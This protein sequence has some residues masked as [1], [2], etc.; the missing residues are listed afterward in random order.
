MNDDLISRNALLEELSSFSMKITG[1]ANAM[2]F[3]IVEE[4]KKSITKIIDEQPIVYD[5]DKVIERLEERKK[6]LLKD[7][8]LVRIR[9]KKLRKEQW[10]E[11]TK[12]MELLKSS[13]LVVFTDE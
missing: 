6:Y 3:M 10:Q 4:A 11:L 5:M 8:V 2:A 7:F 13:S 1:S 12:L 9:R